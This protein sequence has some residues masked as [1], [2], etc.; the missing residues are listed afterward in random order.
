MAEHASATGEVYRTPAAPSSG[1]R[2]ESPKPIVSIAIA[3]KRRPSNGSTSRNSSQERGVWCSSRIGRPSPQLAQWIVPAGT[4]TK[5]RSMRSAVA[6]SFMFRRPVWFGS[7][8]PDTT[9]RATFCGVCARGI[10]STDANAAKCSSN[11]GSHRGSNCAPHRSSTRP[12]DR[13][14]TPAHPAHTHDQP[15]RP[16]PLPQRSPHPRRGCT[17]RTRQR[18]A[19]LRR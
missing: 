8:C 6:V 13:G 10:D 11:C 5:R 12:R 18:S 16:Q 1:G 14:P 4:S 2:D 15:D 3:R 9:I 17:P 7:S 19:R